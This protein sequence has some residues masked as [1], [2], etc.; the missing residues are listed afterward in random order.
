MPKDEIAMDLRDFFN[1]D[2]KIF[3]VAMIAKKITEDEEGHQ[4]YPVMSSREYRD[5]VEIVFERKFYPLWAV[6]EALGMIDRPRPYGDVL[7]VTTCWKRHCIKLDHM[8]WIDRR[9]YNA[10]FVMDGE[11]H[12][13][14]S[15]DEERLAKLRKLK[16][17]G[18]HQAII[19]QR[20]GVAQATISKACKDYNI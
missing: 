6:M 12:P 7:L 16:A 8:E 19:A 10:S 17:E 13:K 18:F 20:M 14:S 1:P 9:S 11:G 4:F 15:W 3:L 5:S 2:Q